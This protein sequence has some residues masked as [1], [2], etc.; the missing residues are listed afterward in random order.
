MEKTGWNEM[1]HSSTAIGLEEKIAAEPV[2]PSSS[3][4]SS[5]PVPAI[6]LKRKCTSGWTL[7]N[8]GTN[9]AGT[10]TFR[11]FYIWILFVLFIVQFQFTRNVEMP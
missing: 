1:D 9:S 10:T 5:S 2:S 11:N 3:S 4:S 6:K 7:S 8:N